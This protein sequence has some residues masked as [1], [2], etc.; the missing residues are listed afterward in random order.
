MR[1]LLASPSLE[2]PGGVTRSVRRVT[3]TLRSLGH[4]VVVCAPDEDLFPGQVREPSGELRFGPRGR[5]S[6][7][8]HAEVLTS[9]ARRFEPDAIVGY[10]G[11]TA[12]WAACRAGKAADC[13]SV[14]A[15][16]GNDV[17]RDL[18]LDDLKERV[19][20]AIRDASAVT[21]VS[22]EMVNKVKE[23]TGVSATFVTNSVD[24][25]AFRPDPVG[26]TSVRGRL[27]LSRPTL[28]IFGE[29]K[30]KRGV[31]LLG[32]IVEELAQWDVLVVGV[33]RPEAR[34][35]V[36]ARARLIPY[37][38]GEAELCALYSAADVVIQPSIHDG[39][40]NAALEA[41]ACERTVVA[42]PVGGLPDLVEDGVNGY[43][44]DTDEGWQSLLKELRTQPRPLV[45]RT[46]RERVPRPAREAEQ[47]LAVV[48]QVVRRS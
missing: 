28:G 43:L 31:D 27:E 18:D 36:P 2:R 40:P 12:G 9:A 4:D 6:A 25:T 10:Y 16:R 48:A 45:G 19:M 39:M 26:A 14:V 13:P 34:H 17:D 7:A 23:R 20:E 47:L 11:S 42:S 29:V 1:I 8:E 35:H 44:R 15:L 33:V 30:A 22:T 38:A 21:C 41:M 24:T 37:V 3:A 5:D 32:R 46:A